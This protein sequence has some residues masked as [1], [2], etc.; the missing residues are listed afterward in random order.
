MNIWRSGH[1]IVLH[2]TTP[3]PNRC[4]L[5]NE[6]A[7][8]RLTRWIVIRKQDQTPNS[9]KLTLK[10]LGK[11]PLIGPIVTFTKLSVDLSVE[12]SQS[13]IKF[14][15]PISQVALS[16]YQQRRWQI[17]F[18][19]L[20]MLAIT[21][22]L[23]QYVESQITL[24]VAGATIFCGALFLGPAFLWQH[25]ELAII[26]FQKHDYLWL[27][28]TQDNSAF[29]RNLPEWDDAYFELPRQ[30]V[31]PSTERQFDPLT[32]GREKLRTVPVRIFALAILIVS[33]GIIERVISI[34]LQNLDRGLSP[35]F[36]GEIIVLVATI[37]FQ[38]SFLLLLGG[39]L[40]M[41]WLFK[42][43]NQLT[44]LGGLVSVISFLI[45]FVI[46]LGFHAE[47]G[48]KLVSGS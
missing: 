27:R 5:T 16:R 10:I 21:I 6:Y 34:S 7:D 15:L 4:I 37:A 46:A 38:W 32:Q 17:F 24:A 18:F 48:S 8:L 30:E 11:I 20:M 19:T 47:M 44:L 42:S 14:H 36:F 41:R 39:K 2:R 1:H 43:G 25:H 35:I 45:S 23:F 9:T 22:A 29:L 3:L 31:K 13:R 26:D 40:A 28:I 12:I 33:A